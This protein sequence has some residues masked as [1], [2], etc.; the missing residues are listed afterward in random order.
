MPRFHHTAWTIKDGAPA[1]IWAL[2]QSKDGYL[3]LGTGS[4]LFR[5]DGIRFEHVQL[6]D[7]QQLA[8]NNVTAL[9]ILP[10]GEIWIGY[11]I[12]GTSR[13]A[14][15][16]IKHFGVGAQ[17]PGGWVLDFAQ[18]KD[19]TVWAAT[20]S[21]LARFSNGQWQ[22]I[23]ADW[24]YPSQH[25]DWVL[26]DSFGTLWVATGDTVV[27]LRRGSRAFERTGIAS[28]R[29]A[30]L[31]QAPDGAVWV[32]DSLFGSRT[33]PYLHKLK[34]P[35]N[36]TLNSLERLQAK[37]LLFQSDGSLWATDAAH[38]GVEHFALAPTSKRQAV[39][40][41]NTGKKRYTKDLGLTSN[42]AVP[43]LEDSE[44]NI[45]AGTNLGL[46]RFRISNVNV[47]SDLAEMAGSNYALAT[48]GGDQVALVGN[49]W[50][51]QSDGE[52]TFEVMRTPPEIKEAVLGADGI[53]WLLAKDALWTV[54]DKNVERV[55][56]PGRLP[57]DSVNSFAV[58]DSGRLL[59]S[60]SK[61]GVFRYQKDAWVPLPGLSTEEPRMMTIDSKDRL[62]LGYKNGQIALFDGHNI[63]RF[64][65]ADGLDVGYVTTIHVGKDSVLV[66]GEKGLAILHKDGFQS[67]SQSR[68]EAFGGVTGIVDTSDGNIWINGIKGVVQISLA[69]LERTFKD[70][71]HV[72]KYRLFDMQ[73]GLP[74]VAIQARRV[75]TAGKTKNGLLWFAT[76][77]GVASI[78][79]S[80][81]QRNWR[82]P[83]VMVLSLSTA[84]K[85]YP[86]MRRS[87][88]P[89][90][91][92]NIKIS[93]TA[94]SL[95]LPERVQFRYKLE[96][97]DPIWQEAGTRREAFYTNLEPGNYR[98]RV[99]AANNDGVWN[100][101]GAILDFVIPPTFF[102]TR[103]FVAIKVIVGLIV[104]LAIYLL[105]LRQMTMRMRGRLEERHLERE[106]IAR[107]LHDTL[108]QGFQGLI[109]RLQ[110]VAAQ[111]PADTLV[112]QNM[113]RAMDR[114]EEALIEGRDRVKGLRA[115]TEAS[116]E[117][118]EAFA[119]IGGEFPKQSQIQ[120]RL[121]VEGTSRRLLPIP[122]DELYLIGREALVNSYRHAKPM[123]IEVELG[124]GEDEFRL[125][126]RDDGCGI[127][128]NVHEAGSKP[129]HW[130]LAGMRER[131]K[132]IGAQIDIWSSPESGTEID[133]CV[134]ATSAYASGI[135]LSWWYRLR[136]LFSVGR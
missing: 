7:G 120:L 44:G 54:K 106:R 126:I 37:R 100:E 18:D 118:Q 124:Y 98:F 122:Q 112:R 74:G 107:D 60:L 65:H 26:S 40:P 43:L 114:A 69:E 130:G 53:I 11:F 133:V 34:P 72:A 2:A 101:K 28:A 129:G 75:S 23:G 32:S 86:I 4:G 20:G 70:Q 123:I 108:L 12:G 96:G 91:T 73:D 14:G 47:L 42:F 115:D 62:W 57:G 38:G 24:N 52:S 56:L 71:Q 78:N 93:Y 117:L 131:A 94:T 102:Q 111:I 10:S 80:H 113:E 89:K 128:I 97:V 58:D 105:R 13:F 99:I 21:G 8:S 121:V 6:P 85:A 66:A 51:W 127:D 83:S 61:L 77:Q 79:P 84:G 63:K 59:I 27:F 46:N 67:I 19:G 81:I 134:P 125:R 49:G 135:H 136:R 103:W 82:P 9:S 76:N 87:E 15:G 116:G 48:N 95:T 92:T 35:D 22:T 50:L 39:S 110:A 88:L 31:A 68:I 3:W 45:W 36:R 41:F 17:M 25:A 55:V 1:D 16:K 132:R 119:K 64:T 109:L 90:R 29:Y 104:F 30:V 5:F 33:L